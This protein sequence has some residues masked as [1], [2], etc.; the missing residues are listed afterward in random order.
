MAAISLLQISTDLYVSMLQDKL[1]KQGIKNKMAT[2]SLLQI[3]TDFVCIFFFYL[4][5]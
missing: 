1:N 3:Y 4:N 5:F 2:I